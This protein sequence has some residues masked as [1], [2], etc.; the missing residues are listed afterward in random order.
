MG[1]IH[2]PACI[3]PQI[4]GS[5]NVVY[6]A[7]EVNKSFRWDTEKFNNCITNSTMQL[8]SHL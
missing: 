3:N 5:E 2:W 4:R 6:V 8:S 7:S 1:Y